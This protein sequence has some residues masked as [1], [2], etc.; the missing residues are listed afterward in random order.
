VEYWSNGKDEYPTLY[1]SKGSLLSK[2]RFD[3]HLPAVSKTSITCVE[4]FNVHGSELKCLK[5]SLTIVLRVNRVEFHVSP[6]G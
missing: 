5:W 2:Y 4:R 6:N 1:Y 3:Q